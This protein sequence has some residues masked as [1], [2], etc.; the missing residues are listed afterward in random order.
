MKELTN[1]GKRLSVV[2]DLDENAS[3][4]CEVRQYMAH[5]GYDKQT[6]AKF[7]VGDV[8]EFYTGFHDDI[9]ARATIKGFDAQGGIYVYNDC[10]WYPIKNDSLRKIKKVG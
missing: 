6:H 4:R 7:C 8:I 10:Y 2:W 9:R 1:K 3:N 5:H